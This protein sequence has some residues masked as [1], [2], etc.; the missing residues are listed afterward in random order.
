MGFLSYLKPTTKSKTEPDEKVPSTSLDSSD[1]SNRSSSA[2]N[3]QS[4]PTSSYPVGD[5][6]KHE[7][8]V[9]HLYQQMLQRMWV[10]DRIEEGTVLK[11][12][13]DDF[14]CMPPELAEHRGGFYEAVRQLNVKSAMTLNTRVI[15]LFLAKGD[16][17][18]VPLNDNLR[19]QILPSIEYLPRCQKHHF[20]A[21]I[22][23][24]AV[25]VV[26]DDDPTH[27]MARA[28]EIE[29]SMMR[30]VW[31]DGGVGGDSKMTSKRGSRAPS[32][33]IQELPEGGDDEELTVVSEPPRKIVLMQPMLSA[34][35]LLI[36]VVAMGAGWR[37]IA[38][39]VMIDH[40]YL[41]CAIMIVIPLQMWLAL[42]RTL[43]SFHC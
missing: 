18:Y 28:A 4:R 8:M 10:A 7:V 9:S 1:A 13:K 6:V 34:M 38:Q 31:S 26:W 2:V 11:K 32:V 33:M 36:L 15:K 39:E 37:N 29:E 24:R 3:R 42:V 30:M 17:A 14:L 12:G 19:L 5:G 43:T 23:D 22:Q 27:I 35:T 16:M 20:A 41:R 25:L 21:F 40:T